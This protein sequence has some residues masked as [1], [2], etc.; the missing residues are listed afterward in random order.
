MK[1][2]SHSAGIVCDIQY[3]RQLA[4]LSLCL[5]F[6]SCVE[7]T[8]VGTLRQFITALHNIES[9][10][11]PRRKQDE[12]FLMHF[13][14]VLLILSL[15]QDKKVEENLKFQLSKLWQNLESGNLI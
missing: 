4:R 13:H 6:S 9:N 3:R 10:I 11:F 1:F 14:T 12:L 15:A 7:G 8:Q 2:I 5:L